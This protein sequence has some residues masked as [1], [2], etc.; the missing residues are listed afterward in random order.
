MPLFIWPYLENVRQEIIVMIIKP[1]HVHTPH[2]QAT[3]FYI[4]TV[5]NECMLAYEGGVYPRRS[6]L[7]NHCVYTQRECSSW[8]PHSYVLHNIALPY[9]YVWLNFLWN[10]LLKLLDHVTIGSYIYFL[11]QKNHSNKAKPNKPRGDSA[12]F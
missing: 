6:V 10:C 5:E 2:I 12:S 4:F 7:I 8:P 3:Y 9:I 11:S 1:S